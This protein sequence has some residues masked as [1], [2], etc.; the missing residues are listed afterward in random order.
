MSFKKIRKDQI[1]ADYMRLEIES[2]EEFK[3]IGFEIDPIKGSTKSGVEYAVFYVL[4]F[5]DDGNISEHEKVANSHKNLKE[6]IR[7]LEPGTLLEITKT[8]I[9]EFEAKDGSQKIYHTYS[10]VPFEIEEEEPAE[11]EEILTTKEEEDEDF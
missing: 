5:D 9:E 3:F 4:S 1:S 11:D 7:G 10:V 2:T 8:G 6:Q